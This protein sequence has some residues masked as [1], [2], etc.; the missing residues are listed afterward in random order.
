MKQDLHNS[1]VVNDVI[2]IMNLTK[3]IMINFNLF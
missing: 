1:I 3:I 2:M